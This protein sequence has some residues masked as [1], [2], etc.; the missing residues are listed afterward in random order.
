MPQPILPMFS[1]DQTIINKYMAVKKKGDTVYWYQGILPVFS[2]H[3]KNEEL[4][5]LFCCQ[6][7]NMGVATSAEIS[8]ALGVN[9]EKLSRWARQDCS[10]NPPESQLV[11]NSRTS[12]TKKKRTS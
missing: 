8:R 9:H 10:S 12:P 11:S 3:V 4:F 6:M 2:H 7:I 5:R 1:D